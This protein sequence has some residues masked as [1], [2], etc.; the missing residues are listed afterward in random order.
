M[1]C[2]AGQDS[3]DQSSAPPVPQK[4]A[5]EAAEQRDTGKVGAV[6][7]GRGHRMELQTACLSPGL[8]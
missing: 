8:G 5:N 1:N 3:S 4:A 2:R 7:V 6:F